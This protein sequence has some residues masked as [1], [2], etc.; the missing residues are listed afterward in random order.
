MM[1]IDAD[2]HIAVT[3]TGCVPD[4]LLAQQPQQRRDGPKD[5]FFP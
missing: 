4:M 5:V 3:I 2:Q 1:D